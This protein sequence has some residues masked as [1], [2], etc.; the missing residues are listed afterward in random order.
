M[1]ALSGSYEIDMFTMSDFFV[2]K[3]GDD[4]EP[5]FVRDMNKLI[6]AVHPDGNWKVSVGRRASLGPHLD[7]TLHTIMGDATT[8][9]AHLLCT[10]AERIVAPHQEVRS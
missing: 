4:G 2:S 3:E 6:F 5:E 1:T 8:G 10:L 9:A 7:A